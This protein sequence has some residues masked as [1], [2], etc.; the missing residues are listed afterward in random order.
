MLSI[1]IAPGGGISLLDVFFDDALHVHP[2]PPRKNQLIRNC[3]LEGGSFSK[4]LE[5]YVSDTWKW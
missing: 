1:F 3:G 4:I 5:G 2:W